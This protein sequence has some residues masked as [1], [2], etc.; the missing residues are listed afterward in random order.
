[1][2]VPTFEVGGYVVPFHGREGG[3]VVG[4]VAEG[5]GW[6]VAPIC[7]VTAY[8][9]VIVLE[10]WLMVEGEAISKG[11]G[12]RRLL[13]AGL[14]SSIVGLDGSPIVG[15]IVSPV[16]DGFRRIGAAGC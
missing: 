3:V 13:G 5:K 1:M 14:A 6:A 8:V 16:D 10:V 9:T 4:G 15:S 2:D 12:D 11:K 7:P